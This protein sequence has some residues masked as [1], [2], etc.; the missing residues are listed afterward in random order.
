[1]ISGGIEADFKAQKVVCKKLADL[2][3]K[4]DSLHLTTPA[5]TDIV[6]N[7]EG[8]RG[9]VLTG[10]VDEPGMFSTIP[11]IEANVSP[12]EGSSEGKII[13]DASV[14][15]LDIGLLRE[16]INILVKKRL[17]QRNKRRIPSRCIEKKSRRKKG[18]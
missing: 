9:N 4:S 3:T 14:P 17:Y 15:Y 5:G 12:V 8:R 10:I 11:T 1:M 13:V 2:F 18:S 16:P 7:I 6:M